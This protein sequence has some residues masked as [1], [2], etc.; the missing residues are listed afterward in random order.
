ML[1]DELLERSQAIREAYH[2]L[3]R[4]HHGSEWTVEEDLL[5]LTNDI[6]NVARL[7]MT[8]QG[9]YYDETPYDLGSKLA[10]NIWWLLELAQRLDIHIQEEMETFLREKETLLGLDKK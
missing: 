5:A 6:G 4:K 9:R 1:P 7:A 3:E 2:G 10:E 8:Q